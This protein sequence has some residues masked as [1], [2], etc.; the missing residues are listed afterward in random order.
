MNMKFDRI[1]NNDGPESAIVQLPIWH[2]S[3]CAAVRL[4]CLKLKYPGKSL[5]RYSRSEEIFCFRSL[6]LHGEGEHAI[7]PDPVQ[8]AVGDL[9]I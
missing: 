7:S 6:A 9:E 1:H 4:S 2:L 3:I 5:A 8:D